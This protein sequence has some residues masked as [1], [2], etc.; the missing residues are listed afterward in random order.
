L[1]EESIYEADDDLLD[2]DKYSEDKVFLED[3][4]ILKM[5]IV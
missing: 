5:S 1:I 3:G 2:N 4:R